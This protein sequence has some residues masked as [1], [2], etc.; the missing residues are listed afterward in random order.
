VNAHLA[1]VSSGGLEAG[2]GLAGLALGG[3]GVAGPQAGVGQ[4][5]ARLR[6]LLL[7]IPHTVLEELFG[8]GG[9]GRDPTGSRQGAFGIL[10][11]GALRGVRLAGSPAARREA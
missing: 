6:E 7:E 10:D 9:R 2:Q 1:W 3:L 8:R 11:G 5:S 4:V